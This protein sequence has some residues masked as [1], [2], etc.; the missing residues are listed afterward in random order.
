VTGHELR[1]LLER[2]GVSQVAAA[3]ALAID[4]RTMRRYLAAS[5]R[6]VPRV[7]ELAVQYAIE[8]GLIRNNP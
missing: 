3:E 1:V 6:Q 5:R 7:V 4:P 8:H 2:A